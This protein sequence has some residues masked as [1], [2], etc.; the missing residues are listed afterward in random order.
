M[1]SQILVSAV[2]GAIIF[3]LGRQVFGMTAMIFIALGIFL[4]WLLATGKL[5]QFL[6]AFTR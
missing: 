4:L 6:S 2:V 5:E 3:E 1:V